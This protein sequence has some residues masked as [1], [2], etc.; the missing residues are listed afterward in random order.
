MNN[1]IVGA[2]FCLIA[3][4]L[5]GARYLAAAVFMSN[6]SNWSAELF[7]A[8]LTYVGP[9]LL[10]TAVIALV[11]GIVFLVCGVVQDIRKAGN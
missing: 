4:I 9:V 5:T 1:K 7:N 6:T 11:A 10:I 8:A 3:A 2:V